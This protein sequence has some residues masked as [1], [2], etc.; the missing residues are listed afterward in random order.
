MDL[1]LQWCDTGFAAT[2]VSW[3]I[4]SAKTE[5]SANLLQGRN[6][7]T[8]LF[9]NLGLTSTPPLIPTRLTNPHSRTK[10]VRGSYLIML[11]CSGCFATITTSSLAQDTPATNNIAQTGS[12]AAPSSNPRRG[13]ISNRQLANGSVTPDR[14]TN[15]SQIVVTATKRAESI[16]DVPV[17]VIVVTLGQLQSQGLNDVQ[18]LTHAVPGLTAQGGSSTTL[19]ICG[20]GV[21]DNARTAESSVGI[22]LDGVAL[23]SNASAGPP[24]LFDVTRVEV[25]EGPQGTL[26]GRS[27]SAG[28]LNITTNAPDPNKTQVIIHADQGSRDSGTR[29]AVLNLPTS[30]YSALRLSLA[31]N[32]A[33]QTVYNDYQ[34]SW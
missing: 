11:A 14:A 10:K 18:D 33:P 22:V 28:V 5:N 34:H 31:N 29:N 6:K 2:A 19:E 1:I 24:Q 23:D 25:L 9:L 12:A 27:T 26:F 21:P 13:N 32:K 15:L 30:T 17:P 4:D 8:C 3:P 16:Q 20:I 7:Q